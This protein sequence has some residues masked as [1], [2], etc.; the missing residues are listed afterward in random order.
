M[1]TW[2]GK[3]ADAALAGDHISLKKDGDKASIVFVGAVLD[4]EDYGA[5]IYRKHWSQAGG[6]SFCTRGPDDTVEACGRCSDGEKPQLRGAIPVWDLEL[7]HQRVLDL[8]WWYVR[9]YHNGTFAE[10]P[11]DK[12]SYT[13]KRTEVDGK[14]EFQMIATGPIAKSVLAA[15]KAQGILPMS[16]IEAVISRG[17]Q[18]PEKF[19]RHSADG[20]PPIGDDE[21]F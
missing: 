21:P 9:N 11:P 1:K 18:K 5:L 14:T 17:Q 7:G 15:I 20:P 16:D 12:N 4:L 3:Q 8:S 19:D 10:V 13:V 6:Y 2:T